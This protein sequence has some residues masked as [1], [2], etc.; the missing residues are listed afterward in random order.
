MLNDKQT[1][2]LIMRTIRAAYAGHDDPMD[3]L[4]VLTSALATFVHH[5]ADSGAI[6]PIDGTG[7]AYERLMADVIVAL[8][9]D[10][11]LIADEATTLLAPSPRMV[12]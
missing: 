11:T 7:P 10:G 1:R 5:A 4:N 9:D 3:A 12:Q 2:A 8:Q 6:T